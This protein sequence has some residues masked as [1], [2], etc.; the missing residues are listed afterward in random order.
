[1][2]DLDKRVLEA[3]EKRGLSPRPYAH[4]LA[5]RSM[6][7]TL[8]AVSILLGGIS[9]AVAIFAVEDFMRTGGRN[10]TDMPFDDVFESLPIIWLLCF[11]LFIASAYLGLSNTRRGYR[12]RPIS[13]IAMAAAAS[14]VLGLLLHVLDVGRAIHGV[15]AAQFASYREFTYVPYDEWRRPDQGY[16]GGEV[17]SVKEGESLRLKDFDGHEWEVDITSATVSFSEPLI[18]EGDVAI[19]G[20]RTGPAA[21]KAKTIDEFD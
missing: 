16:L 11:L 2:S 19:R 3:I 10:F 7:W 14:I 8:A 1:M 20:E 17:L 4:F 15:L 21:F 18:E 6:F 13:V 5:R 9:V 12:Y